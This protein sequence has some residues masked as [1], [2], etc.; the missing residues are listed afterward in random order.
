MFSQL[1]ITV[2]GQSENFLHSQNETWGNL[3]RKIKKFVFGP[4]S[5][6]SLM[7]K[8]WHQRFSDQSSRLAASFE[9]RFIPSAHVN[10]FLPRDLLHLWYCEFPRPVLGLCSRSNRRGRWQTS[11]PASRLI[12]LH[13]WTGG[14]KGP[15]ALCLSETSNSQN[16]QFLC[17]SVRAQKWLMAISQR[18]GGV[19]RTRFS[20]P[21]QIFK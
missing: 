10:T 15:Q 21:V 7:A 5:N 6:V 2:H 20:M 12:F 1:S 4:I 17:P 9:I 3:Q 14:K 13:L 18:S 8:N 11:H 19:K 16:T